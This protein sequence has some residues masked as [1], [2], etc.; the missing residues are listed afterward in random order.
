MKKLLL[1]LAAGTGLLLFFFCVYSRRTVWVAPRSHAAVEVYIKTKKPV[2]KLVLTTTY[3]RQIIYPKELKYTV[4]VFPN[5]GE[6]I[7]KLCCEFKD[8]TEICT[9]EN[10]IESGYLPLL[11]ITGDTIVG[12]KNF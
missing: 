1:G 10:Y 8:G 12:V 6:G 4:F 9:Q 3:S 5:P 11:E 2:E 7:Y